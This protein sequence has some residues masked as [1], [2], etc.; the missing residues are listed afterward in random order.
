MVCRCV[1]ARDF[2][3]TTTRKAGSSA[4][5]PPGTDTVQ[6]P[7]YGIAGFALGALALLIPSTLLN[8]AVG[9]TAGAAAWSFVGFRSGVGYVGCGVGAGVGVVV[10]I[11]AAIALGGLWGVMAGRA[12]GADRAINAEWHA[13]Q[14][15]PKGAS[16]PRVKRRKVPRRNGMDSV[17]TKHQTAAIGLNWAVSTLFWLLL[18]LSPL[19]EH[20][21]TAVPALLCG[22]LC[23]GLQLGVFT[24]WFLVEWIDPDGISD[25]SAARCICPMPCYLQEPNGKYGQ[26]TV[27]WDR[28]MGK[29]IVGIDHWCRWLNT[30]INIRTYPL[31]FALVNV[32]GI[33]F[34]CQSV[35]GALAVFWWIPSLA[36]VMPEFFSSAAHWGH[37]IWCWCV[38]APSSLS[39]SLSLSHTHAHTRAHTH[40]RKHVLRSPRPSFSLLSHPFSPGLLGLDTKSSLC[41]CAS[42]ATTSHVFIAA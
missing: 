26:R 25:W 41:S 11:I 3:V 36:L 31:F 2:G 23:G 28:N 32:A 42:S 19:W 21:S 13:A 38:F 10:G 15:L 14:R 7:K 12:I 24:L 8:G 5:A 4:P 18:G 35:V 22:L 17:P 16:R 29:R 40:A 37:W 6:Q 39:L 27:R 30:T 33:Q 20:P 1:Q 9:C 34:I